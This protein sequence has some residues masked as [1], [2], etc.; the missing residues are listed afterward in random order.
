MVL[1]AIHC[2][3][4]HWELLLSG[5]GR[6][7]CAYTVCSKAG[8][9]PHHFGVSDFISGRNTQPCTLVVSFW[10]ALSSP[11]EISTQDCLKLYISTLCTVW[12]QLGSEAVVHVLAS[13]RLNYCNSLLNCYLFSFFTLSAAFQSSAAR[14]VIWRALF[15][16]ITACPQ[17]F[18]CWHAQQHIDLDI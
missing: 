12:T 6:G 17:H 11:L 4:W 14:F 7:C 8:Q 5:E 9:E 2:N 13:S 15:H 1:T 3:Q 10:K 18:F 16:H